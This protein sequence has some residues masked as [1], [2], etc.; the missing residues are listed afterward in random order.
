MTL[1]EINAANAAAIRSHLSDLTANYHKELPKLLLELQVNAEKFAAAGIAAEA[2]TRR[3]EHVPP[4]PGHGTTAPEKTPGT[5]V[6]DKLPKAPPVAKPAARRTT[7]RR[8]AK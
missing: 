7:T 4:S 1:D 8:T 3:A 6:H 5:L 2:E